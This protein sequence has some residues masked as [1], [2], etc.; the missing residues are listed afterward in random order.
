ME[1]VFTEIGSEL[2]K[3]RKDLKLSPQEVAKSI[4]VHHKYITAIEEGR[5][6]DIPGPIYRV[7]YLRL[8]SDYLKQNTKQLVDKYK[9]ASHLLRH[10][11]SVMMHGDP[12]IEELNPSPKIIWISLLLIIITYSV[13]FQFSHYSYP[14]VDFN[15]NNA[16]L[17]SIIRDAAEKIK[18]QEN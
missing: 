13:W 15:K 12:N 16:E 18:K 11:E 10:T 2:K 9:E 8:Y 14:P 4:K 6:I 3:A 7:G 5:F 1:S 17:E